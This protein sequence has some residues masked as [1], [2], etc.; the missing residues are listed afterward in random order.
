MWQADGATGCPDVQ[1]N[2]AMGVC[3]RVFLG[4]TCISV[5][6]LSKADFLINQHPTATIWAFPSL[7]ELK[8]PPDCYC[9]KA[10]VFVIQKQKSRTEKK[11]THF[12]VTLVGLRPTW[13]EKMGFAHLIIL[14]WGLCVGIMLLL[15][16]ISQCPWVYQGHLYDS[17]SIVSWS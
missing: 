4:D 6:S 7:P 8:Q 13:K 12:R 10:I 16:G 1:S 17:T 5:R 3:E 2:T 14:G 15:T 11:T 9:F